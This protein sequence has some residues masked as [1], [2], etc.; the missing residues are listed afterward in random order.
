MIETVAETSGR[1][2]NATGG[3]VAIIAG[4]LLCMVSVY[5]WLDVKGAATRYYRRT[6]TSWRKIPL[7][8]EIWAERT[9]YKRFRRQALGLGI[10]GI[11][12]IAAGI[13]GVFTS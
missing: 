1:A 10:I 5:L 12:M 11:L 3:I 13:F 2:G 7:V 6:I 4:F 8:G 9:P